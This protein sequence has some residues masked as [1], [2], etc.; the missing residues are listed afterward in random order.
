MPHVQGTAGAQLHIHLHRPRTVYH[1]GADIHYST[2]VLNFPSKM[3]LRCKQYGSTVVHAVYY[4]IIDSDV[5]A[6]AP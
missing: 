6:H 3:I 4:A 1:L 5:I 2:A